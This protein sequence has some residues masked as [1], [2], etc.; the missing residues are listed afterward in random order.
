MYS[1]HHFAIF[2]I[3]EC[4]T[5]SDCPDHL[6]CGEDEDCIDPPCPDCAANG[7]CEGSNHVGICACNLGYLG[8]PYVDGCK[9]KQNLF[10]LLNPPFIIIFA[11][12][13]SNLSECITDF[14]CP[15]YLACGEEEEC[16]SAHC[17]NCTSNAHCKAI[18]HGICTCNIGYEG[19][20]SYG[21]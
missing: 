10:H 13:K 8:D 17:P 19:C 9:R 12:S 6:A 5:D 15:D 1:V 16:V 21:K 2:N 11:T 18:N 4:I 14:D 20:N 3:S 7:H